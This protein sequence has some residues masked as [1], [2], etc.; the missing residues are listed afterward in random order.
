MRV[1]I[2]AATL[3]LVLAGCAGGVEKVAPMESAAGAAGVSGGAPSFVW[4]VMM[5]DEAPHASLMYAP[6]QSDHILVTLSCARASGRIGIEAFNPGTDGTR[7]LLGS[8][9]IAGLITARR[10]PPDE[11][12]GDA[13]VSIVEL[14]TDNPVLTAFRE[15]GLL[16]VGTPLA[17]MNADTPE[18]KDAI[19]EFFGVCG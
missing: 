10:L 4:Q 6:R 12:Y 3:A 2:G 13:V 18:E 14:K 7:L 5:Q 16:T 17:P 19:A 9:E 11:F 8:G 1:V 15:S